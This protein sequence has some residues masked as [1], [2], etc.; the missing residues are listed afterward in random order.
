[1]GFNGSQGRLGVTRSNRFTD[2][3]HMG[4]ARHFSVFAGQRHHAQAGNTAVQALHDFPGDVVPCSLEDESIKPRRGLEESTGCF[5]CGSG[6][7]IDKRFAQTPLKIRCHVPCAGLGSRRFKLQPDIVDLPCIVPVH[8]GDDRPAIGQML[9]QTFR[10]EI[11]QRFSNHRTADAQ[12][13]AE[14]AL[15][16]SVA[17]L[18]H[19][20]D[21]RIA[22]AFKNHVSQGGGLLLN[23]IQAKICH[24]DEIA[25]SIPASKVV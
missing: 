14:H 16:Q 19:A 3:A 12:L 9:H 1:M 4:R 21:Y 17:R 6:F 13:L 15:N 25:A 22:Q 24:A 10:I 2:V 5:L 11:A 18:E 20:V 7:Q 8:P 23:F